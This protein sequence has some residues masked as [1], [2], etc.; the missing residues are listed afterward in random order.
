MQLRK[1]LR[2]L[3]LSKTPIQISTLILTVN[4]KTLKMTPT[5]TKLWTSKT[6]PLMCLLR[7]I[8]K[9]TPKVRIPEVWI[10]FK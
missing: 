4:M 8:R 7:T 9:A 10:G 6:L 2:F 3:R 1:Q 5:R